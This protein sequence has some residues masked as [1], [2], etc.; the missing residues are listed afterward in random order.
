VPTGS[1]E[2]GCLACARVQVQISAP[3]PRVD[4]SALPSAKGTSGTVPMTYRHARPS[5][6]APA[7]RI[8]RRRR[9]SQSRRPTSRPAAASAAPSSPWPLCR[10]TTCGVLSRI[11]RGRPRSTALREAPEADCASRALYSRTC[12]CDAASR[13]CLFG[14]VTASM[15]SWSP[16]EGRTVKNALRRPCSVARGLTRRAEWSVHPVLCPPLFLVPVRAGAGQGGWWLMFGAAVPESVT[17]AAVPEQVRVAR[18]FVAR[19]LGDS[20]VQAD[21]ALLLA[22]ELVTNSVR[23]SGSAVPGG[24]VTV[25]VAAVDEAVRVEVTDRSGDGV[26]VLPSAAAAGSEAE[27]SRGLWLVEALAARW[28]YQR[29]GGLATTWFELGQA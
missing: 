14:C 1:Q 29:G 27:G 24:V 19:V 25:T 11:Y 20:H 17:I 7:A 26:P 13:A 18:A 9:C 6:S 16:R 8:R 10:C 28:G 2:P 4:E 21:V 3:F 15:P 23:H 5:S 12:L 22:S